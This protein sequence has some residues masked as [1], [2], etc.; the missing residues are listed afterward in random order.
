[1]TGVESKIIP[2]WFLGGH[3]VVIKLKVHKPAYHWW[4]LSKERAPQVSPFCYGPCSWEMQRKPGCGLARRDADQP[5]LLQSWG[6]FPKLYQQQTMGLTHL[7]IGTTVSL[8]P[9]CQ[10]NCHTQRTFWGWKDYWTFIMCQALSQ[11]LG[12]LSW[13][14]FVLQLSFLVHGQLFSN[15]SSCFNPKGSHSLWIIK[16]KT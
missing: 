16:I 7:A 14:H 1:M 11:I 15:R 10:G 3:S 4:E 8:P 13:I 12:L 6:P 5:H 9:C 2:A